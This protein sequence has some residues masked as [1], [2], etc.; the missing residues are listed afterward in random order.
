MLKKTVPDL[1]ITGTTEAEFSENIRQSMKNSFKLSL[2]IARGLLPPE[3]II[4]LT[5]NATDEEITDFLTDLVNKT[6]FTQKDEK[7]FNTLFQKPH[8]F[9]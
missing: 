2:G 7:F 9:L 4:D 6:R 5:E 8:L 1:P 3:T